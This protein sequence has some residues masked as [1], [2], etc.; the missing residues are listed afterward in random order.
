MKEGRD[1]MHARIAT[2]TV[3]C[4]DVRRLAEFWSAVLGYVPRG[5]ITEVGGLAGGVIEDPNDRDVELMFLRVP[6]GTA[7]Q[8]RALM[9]LGV[10]DLEAEI[11][12]FIGLGATQA[13]G[14][15]L[16]LPGTVLRDPEGNTFCVFG[17]D[18]GN[19]LETWRT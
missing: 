9:I 7:V 2:M 1:A 8:G 14:N 17:T 11:Q 18:E 12:R 10:D 3:E 15:P 4:S 16:S 6:E 19:R 13:D 5:E